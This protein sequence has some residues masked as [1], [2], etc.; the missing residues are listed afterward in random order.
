VVV[1]VL[2]CLVLAP[3]TFVFMGSGPA[4]QVWLL[5]AALV[6]AASV[7]LAIK[8]RPRVWYRVES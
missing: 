3:F 4:L 7:V 2:L 6:T 5:L 8:L 1:G